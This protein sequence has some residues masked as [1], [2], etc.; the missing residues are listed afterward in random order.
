MAYVII[1]CDD[2]GANDVYF[3]GRLFRT[4]ASAS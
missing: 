4:E 1:Y 3:M 2:Q